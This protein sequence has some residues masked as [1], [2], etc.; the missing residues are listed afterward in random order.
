MLDPALTGDRNRFAG[1]SQRFV[2]Q[3]LLDAAI[4]HCQLLQLIEAAACKLNMQFNLRTGIEGRD[5]LYLLNGPFNRIERA[6]GHTLLGALPAEHNQN[7]QR[8]GQ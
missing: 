7:K 3:R 2:E 4:L 6:I 1:L 5:H 8:R